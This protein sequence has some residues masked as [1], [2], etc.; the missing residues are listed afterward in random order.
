LRKGEGM[1]DKPDSNLRNL[2]D[3]LTLGGR[4]SKS[5]RLAAVSIQKT[6]A[7]RYKAAER[8]RHEGK[9]DAAKELQQCVF[10]G[11]RQSLGEDHPE[12]LQSLNSLILIYRELGDIVRANELSI[13]LYQSVNRIFQQGNTGKVRLENGQEILV[14]FARDYP[15]TLE[16]PTGRL[17]HIDKLPQSLGSDLLATQAETAI[18]MHDVGEVDAARRILDSVLTTGPAL[19][20]RDR[21]TVRRRLYPN[22]RIPDLG[23]GKKLQRALLLDSSE[24]LGP[25]LPDVH[26]ALGDLASSLRSF[27]SLHPRPGQT[28]GS[29]LKFALLDPENALDE[30]TDTKQEAPSQDRFANVWISSFGK[31]ERVVNKRHALEPKRKYTLHLTIG[32]QLPYSAVENPGP[33]PQDNLPPNPIGHWLEVL[34]ASDEFTLEPKRHHMFLPAKGDAFVCSCT[35]G[36]EHTCD[37]SERR[38]D[39]PIPI[40]TPVLAA[41][42][43]ADTQSSSGH[44]LADSLH[45]GRAQ[46]R[47]AIYFRKNLVQSLLLKARISASTHAVRK[48]GYSARIDYS[49]T[50]R[51]T[52]VEFLPV[53]TLNILT[54]DNGGGNHRILFNGDDGDPVTFNVNENQI[55]EAIRAARIT[56]KNTGV[57]EFGGELGA[58]VQYENLYDPKNGKPKAKFIDDL[59]MMAS[60]GFTLWATLFQKQPE[61]REKITSL[62]A[63]FGSKPAVIQVSRVEDTDFMF[64]WA[65]IYDIPMESTVQPSLCK[66][67]DT[68]GTAA[69]PLDHC[70]FEQDHAK[71]NLLCPFGFWGFKHIIE[72]PPS[73]P[74]NRALPMSITKRN[75]ADKAQVVMGIS[76]ELDSK[77]TTN[78]TKKLKEQAAFQLALNDSL[79]GLKQALAQDQLEFVYLYCHGRR[80]PLP[81]STTGTP[82]LAV[83]K[84]KEGITPTD[85]IAW[86]QLSWS[87]THWTQTSPLVFINGC[88]TAELTPEVLVNFIDIFVG[89]YA[90]GVIGTEILL[91]Q[92]AAGEAAEQILLKLNTQDPRG[93]YGS[94]GESVREMRLHFAHKGS[95]LGLAYTPYCCADL[96]L[97]N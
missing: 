66:C 80:N 26:L 34:V 23:I 16:L 25:D 27:G 72:L 28:G 53:R 3:E 35:P 74:S 9:L 2:L 47:L 58:K 55:G 90:S 82:L 81:G 39:L 83:G 45:F 84:D 52:D 85:I 20:G 49:L 8:L 79:T 40:T 67:L 38:A 68:F 62:L 60:L 94:V 29:T 13:I 97:A 57:R 46:L 96:K 51:L 36:G 7:V 44:N 5:A 91:L 93:V 24:V 41:L 54:N 92:S 71:G 63:G 61:D 18:A 22:R 89:V 48:F 21:T 19:L 42:A 65:M 1:T 32:Q 73:M 64:P 75:P 59:R 14:D 31:L 12:T 56:L 4:K 37:S 6:L 95:L 86:K 78:H 70:P 87:K 50:S 17:R 10:A 33:F 15:V 77:Q 76:L 88:H 11:R 69:A 43:K 30:K